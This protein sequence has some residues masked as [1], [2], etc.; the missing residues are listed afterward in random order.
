MP[1]SIVGSMSAT[2]TTFDTP[3]AQADEIARRHAENRMELVFTSDS[4]LGATREG[5][6]MCATEGNGEATGH[7]GELLQGIFEDKNGHLHR[8]LVSLPCRQLKSKAKFRANNT[9]KISIT[10]H[11]CRK[12]QRAAEL[13][14]KIFARI[15]TGGHLAIESNIPVGRGMGSSTADTLASILAVLDFLGVRPSPE[16]IMQVAVNAE[17]ACDSTLFSQQAVLFAH[18]EG[19]VIEAF[20]N[21]LPPIDYISVDAT[22]GQTVDTLAFEPAQYS[23]AEIETFRPLRGL[24]RRAINTSDLG[25]LGRVSTASARINDKFLRKPRFHDIEAIGVRYSA[26]G[27]QVAH[28]GTVVGLMFDPKDKN[29]VQNMERATHDLRSSGFE[30]S[31]VSHEDQLEGT[32]V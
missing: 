3:S 31:I 4:K 23:S 16:S 13:A 6:A 20:R 29:A 19:I 5:L 15:G 27:I 10:P 28:S 12:A 11:R 22:P 1:N 17:T 25:L 7:H 30:P 21:S 24:L 32:N 26:V 18:R 2:G 8:G 9:E 14:L